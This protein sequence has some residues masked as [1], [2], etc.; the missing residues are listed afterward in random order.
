[1]PLQIQRLETGDAG[2]SS[3]SDDDDEHTTSKRAALSSSDGCV[4]LLS[5]S[6]LQPQQLQQQHQEP[7]VMPVIITHV[8]S[9]AIDDEQLRHTTT[10]FDC[11]HGRQHTVLDYIN[12]R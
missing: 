6:I 8:E 4:K 5:H 1:M 7:F 3:S 12:E 2:G 9:R 10:G 11:L